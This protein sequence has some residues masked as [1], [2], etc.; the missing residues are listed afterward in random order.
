MLL[1]HC[2]L[3]MHTRLLQAPVSRFASWTNRDLAHHAPPHPPEFYV[4][5]TGVFQAPERAARSRSYARVF[6]SMGRGLF[7]VAL[8]N[9]AQWPVD[10]RCGLGLQP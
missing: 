3:G 1:Q 5:D 6:Q 9:H 7:V 8:G 4:I 2:R 10:N